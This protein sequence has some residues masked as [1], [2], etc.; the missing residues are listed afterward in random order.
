L[1][2]GLIALLLLHSS[3][4]SQSD[5]KTQHWIYGDGLN[6]L[7]DMKA[8]IEDDSISIFPPFSVCDLGIVITGH[9]IS[10]T[11]A[12]KIGDSEN[13]KKAWKELFERLQHRLLQR[14]KGA[15]S[16]CTRGPGPHAEFMICEFCKRNRELLAS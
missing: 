16:F 15:Q 2:G 12:Y 3:V 10:K 7:E 4:S 8:V 9:D 11:S 5:F 13:A 6:H 14:I 1:C